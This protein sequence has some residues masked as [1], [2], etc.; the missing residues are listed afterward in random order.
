MSVVIH[1]EMISKPE[2]FDAVRARL[3]L[4]RA[5]SRRE[6]GCLVFEVAEDDERPGRFLIWEIYRDAEALAHHN[7]QPYLHEVREFL[8]SHLESRALTRATVLP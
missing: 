4:H 6:P 1:V 2:H 8:G 7:A 3:A 5:N